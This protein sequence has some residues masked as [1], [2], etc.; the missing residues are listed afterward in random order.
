VIDPDAILVRT[1]ELRPVD[2]A[3]IGL[4]VNDF[5]ELLGLKG[6]RPDRDVRALARA[7][8]R[9]RRRR[10]RADVDEDTLAR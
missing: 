6:R 2:E 3:W 9:A 4:S 8:A 10:L 5:G 7:R 1:S